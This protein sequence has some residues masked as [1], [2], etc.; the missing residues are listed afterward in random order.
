MSVN[1]GICLW[2]HKSALKIKSNLKKFKSNQKLIPEKKKNYK[3]TNN[4]HM[5]ACKIT[6]KIKRL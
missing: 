6:I 5:T 2:R 1:F 3:K 4:E